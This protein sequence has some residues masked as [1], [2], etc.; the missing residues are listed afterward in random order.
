MSIIDEDAMFLSRAFDELP[1]ESLAPVRPERT[2][3]KFALLALNAPGE[4]RRGLASD[5]TIL[6]P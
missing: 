2:T 5:R 1:R 3:L 4:R 6:V